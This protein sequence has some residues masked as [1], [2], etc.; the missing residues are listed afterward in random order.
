MNLDKLNYT[1][2][3]PIELQDKKHKI[4]ISL[5]VAGMFLMFFMRNTF[6]GFFVG[7]GSMSLVFKTSFALFERWS[8]KQPYDKKYLPYP[9]LY[10]S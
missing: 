7:F 2:Q 5:A 9:V 3:E 10:F 6:V 4:F 8:K 1:N